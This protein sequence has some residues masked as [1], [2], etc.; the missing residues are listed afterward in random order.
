MRSLIASLLVATL[1]AA[2]P[3][4]AVACV[5]FS[6]D[7]WLRNE[8][9]SLRWTFDRSRTVVRV[10]VVRVISDESAQVTTI[11]KFKGAGE[12]NVIFRDHTDCGVGRFRV[13]DEFVAFS[14]NEFRQEVGMCNML[15][16]PVIEMLRKWKR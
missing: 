4:V 7:D 14:H 8:A 12:V 3:K 5:C 9:E 15:D 13:G 10:R 2:A 1:V 16:E 11:E 6:E